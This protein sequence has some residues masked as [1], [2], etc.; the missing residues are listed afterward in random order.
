ML[1]QIETLWAVGEI[2]SKHSHFL[3]SVLV[4]IFRTTILILKQ[5]IGRESARK[6]EAPTQADPI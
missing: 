2:D 5:N 4:F 3:I 1:G 6:I